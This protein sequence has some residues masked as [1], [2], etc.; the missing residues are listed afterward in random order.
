MFLFIQ[1]YKLIYYVVVLLVCQ[2]FLRLNDEEEVEQF[3]EIVDAD[4][5][6]QGSKRKTFAIEDVE[7]V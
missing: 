5:K 3:S 2:V 4:Q 1:G 7:V 6:G